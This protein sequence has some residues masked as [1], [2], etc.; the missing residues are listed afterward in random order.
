MPKTQKLEP[1]AEANPQLTA[2]LNVLNL[3][4]TVT[5]SPQSNGNSSGVESAKSDKNDVTWR[6]SSQDVQTDRVTHI[7]GLLDK[8]F[9]TAR[10]K[11]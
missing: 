8:N 6:P 4:P 1:I 3:E 5:A 11:F 2:T 7:N 9:K 10:F